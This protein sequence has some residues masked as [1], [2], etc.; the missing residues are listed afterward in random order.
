MFDSA[1]KDSLLAKIRS[2]GL[3]ENCHD[4]LNAYLESRVG[5]F[6]IEAVLS[7]AIVL[8]DA[9]FQGTVLGPVL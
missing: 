2:V 3:A 5:R 1:W 6:A 8:C 4:F 7:D 9:I